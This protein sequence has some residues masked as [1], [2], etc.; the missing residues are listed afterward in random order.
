MRWFLREGWGGLAHYGTGEIVM[1]EARATLLVPT[2]RPR[3]LDMELVTEAPAGTRLGIAVNGHPVGETAPGG[4]R[5]V[6][7]IPAAHL[8]RGDN[9]ATL[10]S[11]SGATGARL[12]RL[13]IDPR[14]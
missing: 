13:A 8:F 7:T 5:V 1:H 6:V 2:V 9:Q 3:D 12:R 10:S 4:G 14:P 11:P